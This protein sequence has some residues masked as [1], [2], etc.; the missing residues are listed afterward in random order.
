[1]SLVCGRLAAS[2][3]RCQFAARITHLQI[4]PRQRASWQNVAAAPARQAPSPCKAMGSMAEPDHQPFLNGKG[5][6]EGVEFTHIP[7]PDWQPG[8]KQPNPWNS[9]S[10][11]G[12]LVLPPAPP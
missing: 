2:S 7:H 6:D 12:G 4:D 10:M 5:P 8:E 1:M 9:T 3:V 11:V